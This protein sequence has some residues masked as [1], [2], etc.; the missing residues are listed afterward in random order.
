[1]S[2]TQTTLLLHHISLNPSLFMR[3][4]HIPHPEKQARI[5]MRAEPDPKPDCRGTPK[6]VVPHLH[7][8]RGAT[9]AHACDQKAGCAWMPVRGCVQEAFHIREH[10]D[11]SLRLKYGVTMGPGSVLP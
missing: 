4:I 6:R 2:A 10:R 11:A 3:V 5:Q 8:N 1:M 9:S 7:P